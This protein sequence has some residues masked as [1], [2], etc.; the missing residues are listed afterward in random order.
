MWHN[1]ANVK[2]AMS[3]LEEEKKITI[4]RSFLTVTKDSSKVWK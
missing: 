4:Q 1:Y 2:T 3:G